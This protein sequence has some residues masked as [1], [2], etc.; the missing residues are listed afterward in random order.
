METQDW[1]NTLKHSTDCRVKVNLI[2][3]L[4]DAGIKNAVISKQSKLPDYQVRHYL[5]V[6]RNLVPEV[7]SLFQA[8]KITFSMVRAIA[9]LAPKKQEKAARDAIAKC[10]SVSKF[11]NK[12][13]GSSDQKLTAELER[14]SEHYSGV[15]GL[16]ITIKADKHNPNAGLWVIRYSDLNMY[17][18]IAEKL[19]PGKS[20]NDF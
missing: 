10:T 13:K 16:D 2:G 17:D 19:A 7:M 6:Y 8:G 12:L 9:S 1:L 15:T 14:Q 5:R 3:Q 20:Y 4:A 18:V 11:R